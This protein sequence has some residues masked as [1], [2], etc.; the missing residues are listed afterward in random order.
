MCIIYAAGRTETRIDRDEEIAARRI[1]A[2]RKSKDR[3]NRNLRLRTG[4]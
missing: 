1:R 3:Q 2:N 4:Q